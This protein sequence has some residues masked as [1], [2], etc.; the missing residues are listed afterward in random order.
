MDASFVWRCLTSCTHLIIN[1]LVSAQSGRRYFIL[2]DIYSEASSS[3]KI[4]RATKVEI[5]G[6][7]NLILPLFVSISI[8]IIPLKHCTKYEVFH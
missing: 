2:C 1:V 3:S 8:I 4:R 6:L 5:K 7:I